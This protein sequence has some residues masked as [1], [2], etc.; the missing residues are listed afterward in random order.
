MIIGEGFSYLDFLQYMGRHMDPYRCLPFWK[1]LFLKPCSSLCIH[2]TERQLL[3]GALLESFEN[4]TCVIGLVLRFCCFLVLLGL[5]WRGIDLVSSP[6]PCPRLDRR[7][8]PRVWPLITWTPCPMSLW[9]WCP[10]LLGV[11]EVRLL[12]VGP[13]DLKFQNFL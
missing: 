4:N 8:R 11:C 1:E 9:T 5:K 13:R 3:K 10:L 2:C 12:L 7:L 6:G